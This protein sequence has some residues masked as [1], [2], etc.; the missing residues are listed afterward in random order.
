MSRSSANDTIAFIST[1]PNG[2]ANVGLLE[3]TSIAAP[4]FA[5]LLAEWAAVDGHPFGFLDPEL[6]RIAGYYG[7]HPGTADPFLDVTSG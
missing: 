5:G 7:A 6:Y 4:V 1:N 3:G 2:S